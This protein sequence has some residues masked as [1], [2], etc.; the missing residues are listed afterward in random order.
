VKKV[1]RPKG[2]KETKSLVSTVGHKANC[3]LGG[4]FFRNQNSKRGQSSAIALS[5][6]T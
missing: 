4:R 6:E 5:V 3:G 2:E 1:A